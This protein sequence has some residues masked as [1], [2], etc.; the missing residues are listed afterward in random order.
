MPKNDDG[1]A[2]ELLSFKSSLTPDEQEANQLENEGF[3][4]GE[5]NEQDEDMLTP[6]D[7]IA[8][9]WQI[10]QG[11]VRCYQVTVKHEHEGN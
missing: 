8:F 5:G 4:I 6:G 2:I 3:D 11:M 10:S 7:L 9:A 1:G